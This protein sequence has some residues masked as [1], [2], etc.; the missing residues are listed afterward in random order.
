M[1]KRTAP[2]CDQE[3]A[4]SATPRRVSP[5]CRRAKHA[6]AAA[7][8]IA[9]SMAAA[10]P[11][12][13]YFWWTDRNAVECR[14]ADGDKVTWTNGND[15]VWKYVWN[16]NSNAQE[17][18]CDMHSLTYDSSSYQSSFWLDNGYFK[19]GAGGLT[20][21]QKGFFPVGKADPNDRHLTITAT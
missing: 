14:N 4:A 5:L 2:D 17:I 7:S 21:L 11:V 19:I 10:D 6:I 1:T 9:A 13:Q 20:F 12:T 8:M 15:A 3:F 16:A 18:S